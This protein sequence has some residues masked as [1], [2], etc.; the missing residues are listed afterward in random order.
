MFQ[1][2]SQILAGMPEGLDVNAYGAIMNQDSFMNPAI[3]ADAANEDIE[4]AD[5]DSTT[6]AA[7]KEEGEDKVGELSQT[8]PRNFGAFDGNPVNRN[9]QL[10]REIGI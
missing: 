3:D 7:G 2:R 5:G 4:A 10:M 9:S 6:R 1:R 8:T